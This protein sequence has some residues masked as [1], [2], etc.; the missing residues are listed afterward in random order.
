[1]IQNI[2]PSHSGIAVVARGVL[3]SFAAASLLAPAA[4][5]IGGSST[6][7]AENDRLRREVMGLQGQVSRLEGETDELKTKLATVAKARGLPPGVIASLPV[8]THVELGSY[9]N[10]IPPMGAAAAVRAEFSP[11]DGRDRFVQCVGEV[12]IEALLLSE[13]GKGE[14]KRIGMVTLDAPALRDAYRSGVLGTYYEAIVP[15][16]PGVSD[17]AREDAVLLRLEFMDG[18]N[19]QIHKAERTIKAR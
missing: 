15:L 13:V 6:V 11:K 17:A 18:T 19:D 10:I 9:S 14:P 3:W 16:E 8:V 7:S 2:R 4:C 1:M 5:S 12:R